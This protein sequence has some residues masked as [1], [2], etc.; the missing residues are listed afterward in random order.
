MIKYSII[1][2]YNTIISIE[3][4]LLEALSLIIVLLQDI[5]KIGNS[6]TNEIVHIFIK[7]NVIGD[8]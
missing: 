6:Y 8:K 2:L 7:E 1:P 5:N 3:R 4:V